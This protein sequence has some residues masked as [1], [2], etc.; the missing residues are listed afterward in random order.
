MICV[1]LGNPITLVT[2]SELGLALQRSSGNSICQ[3]WLIQGKHLWPRSWSLRSHELSLQPHHIVEASRYHDPQ[4][5]INCLFLSIITFLLILR[6]LT[7]WWF[8]DRISGEKGLGGHVPS[9]PGYFKN[10]R[11]SPLTVSLTQAFCDIFQ[12]SEPKVL[13]ISTAVWEVTPSFIETV[14]VYCVAPLCS[15]TFR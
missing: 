4:G 8:A 1:A 9:V 2:L 6:E 3:Y 11:G 14:Y 15:F 12:T 10:P 7:P 5:S 13:S